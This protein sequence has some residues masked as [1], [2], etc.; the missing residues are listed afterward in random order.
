MAYVYLFWLDNSFLDF[1]IVSWLALVGLLQQALIF[2]ASFLIS[3]LQGE[4]DNFI[5]EEN[6]R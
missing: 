4:K 2:S 6:Y 5:H 3:Y 1:N